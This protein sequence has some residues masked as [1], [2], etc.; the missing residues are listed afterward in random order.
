MTDDAQPPPRHI[1]AR[2][3]QDLAVWCVAALVGLL[4]TA[5]AVHADT[6]LHGSGAPFPGRHGLRPSPMW[7]LAPLVAAGV[8]ALAV[9]GHF[10]RRPWW[11]V[12]LVAY[13][14][15]LAWALAL[16]L[17]DGLAG[18]TRPVRDPANYAADLAGVADAP[19]RYLRD[20]V[21]DPATHSAAARTHPPGPVLTVWLL[22]RLGLHAPLALALVLTALGVAVVPLVLSAVRGVSGGP[23]A[24]RYAPVLILAP[25]AVWTAVRVDVFVAVLAAAALA[26]AVR[27][28][29][30]ARRGWPA[31]GW[32]L[33]AGLLLGLA[34]LYSYPAAWLGLGAV[35]LYFARR[36]PFLNL[37][38]GLG[39]LAPVL[40]ADALGFP[41]L[42]GLRMARAGAA[43]QPVLCWAA[44]SLVVLLL[45]AGPALVASLRKAR[46][47]DG[48][49]FLVGSGCAVVFSLLAGLAV[50]GVE[51]AWL[52]F[53]PWVTVAVVAPEVQGGD[54]PV[55]PV[56]LVC[57]GAVAGVLLRCF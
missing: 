47:T 39:A 44:V 15:A 23:T 1:G 27:G 34:A 19:G 6:A 33:L 26:A 51:H 28:S 42:S 20:Y 5:W 14:T 16:A 35:C 22:H 10:L 40:A 4:L 2:E 32:T 49:A 53:F 24:R 56:A 57:G 55:T 29:A 43:G 25:Y 13:G 30:P 36:R 9:R 52:A 37:T 45:A 17:A 41:W 11:L 38:T 54:P 21:T 48:W 46:N 8:L 31:T 7:V 12:Q 18:L 50:G 3:W